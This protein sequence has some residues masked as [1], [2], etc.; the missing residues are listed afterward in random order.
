MNEIHTVTAVPHHPNHPQK[1]GFFPRCWGFYATREEAREGL[2]GNVGS[3]AGYYTHAIIERF[4]PGICAIAEQEEW[5]FFEEA[6]NKWIPIPQP[7]F[8]RQ[9]VNYA[10]G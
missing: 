3:E 10:I 9:V 4:T 8:A 1:G 7:E 6:V 2:Q 5:F